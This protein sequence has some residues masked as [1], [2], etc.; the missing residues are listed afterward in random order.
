MIKVQKINFE[1][2][3]ERLEEITRELESGELSLDA[4]LKLFEEGIKLSR[5]CQKKLTETEQ[6]LEILK[7]NNIDDFSEEEL[8]PGPAEVEDDDAEECDDD[9]YDDDEIEP[10]MKKEKKKKKK[11]NDLKPGGKENFLF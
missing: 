4:S 1:K 7:S 3:L 10:V 5:Q 9:D 2:S 8:A 6:K 11:T